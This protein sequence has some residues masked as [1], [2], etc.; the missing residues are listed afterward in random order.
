MRQFGRT[1]ALLIG[2]IIMLGACSSQPEVQTEA[3]PIAKK[4]RWYW[5]GSTSYLDYIGPPHAADYWIEIGDDWM[6]L[7]NSQATIHTACKQAVANATTTKQGRLWLKGISAKQVSCSADK[8]E[9]A[10]IKQLTRISITEQWGDVLRITL[11]QY[12]DAMYFS[13]NPEAGFASYRCS[14]TES[15][16]AITSGATLSVWLGDKFN[17]IKEPGVASSAAQASEH[18]SLQQSEDALAANCRKMFPL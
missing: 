5:M 15:L 13:R 16:A 8:L 2:A 12:G 10:F 14:A 17:Q 1:L 6:G 11:D 9:A 7:G 18:S 4:Q 3:L